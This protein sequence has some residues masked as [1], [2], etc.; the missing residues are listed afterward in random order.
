MRRQEGHHVKVDRILLRIISQPR[1]GGYLLDPS[2]GHSQQ[3]VE[4]V[5]RDGETDAELD[6]GWFL[7]NK[8]NA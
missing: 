5:N 7:R 4:V 6:M 1:S 2:N 8:D 3:S